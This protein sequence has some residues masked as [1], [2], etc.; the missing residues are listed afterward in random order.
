MMLTNGQEIAL[1][2]LGSALLGEGLDAA[3]QPRRIGREWRAFPLRFLPVLVASSVFLMMSGSVL[4]ALLMSGLCLGV[5]AIGSNLKLRLLNEPLVFTDLA[6][7]SAFVKHPRFYLQAVPVPLRF[8]VVAGLLLLLVVLVLLSSLRGYIRL[9]AAVIGSIAALL[10]WR[11]LECQSRVGG[12]APAL[13]DDTQRLGLLPV[14]LLYTCRWARLPPLEEQ[15]LVSLSQ[16]A[17]DGVIII[18]CESFADP[19]KLNP[20]W[21]PLP[22]LRRCQQEALQWGELTPSG[23]GAYTMRSEYSVLCGDSDETLSYRQFDPFLTAH[24]APSHGLARK[25]RD[26]YP[27]ALFLHPYDMR[28]YGRQSLMPQLGFTKLVGKEFFTKADQEGPYVSDA[29]LAGFLESIIRNQ[30]RFL[31]YCVTIE[32]H[33]P[34]KKG[35]LGQKSGAEAWH[36]HAQHSD[37]MLGNVYDDIKDSGKDVLLV[38]FG[39]HRPA[40]EALPPCKGLKRGTPYVIMRPNAPAMITRQCE[41]VPLTMAELHQAIVEAVSASPHT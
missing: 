36:V 28:F 41:P 1:M 38:F 39:D 33:G 32:N 17:P 26:V 4:I 22:A 3:V 6:L 8:V 15:A 31:T 37:A 10:L 40:L 5:L 23:L 21:A 29:A 24:R 14:L 30:S 7:L 20:Q 27:E 35:R 12:P 34:W 9:E 18:Q 11:M 25:L 13:W 19:A 2:I 16:H